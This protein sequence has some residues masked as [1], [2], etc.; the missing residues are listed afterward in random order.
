LIE[1]FKY[2]KKVVQTLVDHN[3]KTDFHPKHQEDRVIIPHLTHHMWITTKQNKKI[4]NRQNVWEMIHKM[5]VE[6]KKYGTNW[7]HYIW[8]NNPSSVYINETVC[9]GRCHI[10]LF[11]EIPDWNQIEFLVEQLIAIKFY[12][13]DFLKPILIYYHGGIYMDTDYNHLRSQ[14]FIHSTMDLYTGDEGGQMGGI[15][16]GVFGARKYH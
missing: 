4:L 13:I 3:S 6:N 11:S 12:A 10:K 2:N 7:Q 8:T 1:Y 14:R 16:A 5:G 15:A 9:E